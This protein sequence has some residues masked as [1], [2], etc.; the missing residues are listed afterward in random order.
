ML[1]ITV[2]HVSVA[3][4]LTGPGPLVC[5]AAVAEASS[6]PAVLDMRWPSGASVA[7]GGDERSQAGPSSG[8][9]DGRA[10][11]SPGKAT[12]PYFLI[13]VFFIAFLLFPIIIC[14]TPHGSMLRVGI[15]SGTCAVIFIINLMGIGLSF[16]EAA[17]VSTQIF[18]TI[19]YGDW[20]TEHLNAWDKVGVAL[21]IVVFLTVPA[22]LLH[23]VHE[24]SL[25]RARTNLENATTQDN[26]ASLK[27]M[28]RVSTVGM[29]LG[30][31]FFGTLFFAFW[32]PCSC[33]DDEIKIRDCNEKDKAACVS[34][35]G[36]VKTFA[37]SLY[38]SVIT[39]TTIGFGDMTPLTTLGHVIAVPWM[40]IGVAVTAQ[41]LT[42]I[43]DIVDEFSYEDP[44][45]KGMQ[46]MTRELFHQ[47]DEDHSGQLSKNEFRIGLLLRHSIVSR[48]VLD[49]IDNNFDAIDGAKAG[50]L[51]FEEIKD[52]DVAKRASTSA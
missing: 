6:W 46:L 26:V 28:H 45:F 33:G 4:L 21:F 14:C 16:S 22:T 8:S 9:A 18:S 17:Y 12:V 49:A 34:T 40:I 10:G 35:G 11:T 15:L 32:E 47:V 20:K 42:Q 38:M 31:V 48:D 24:Y 25:S 2:V 13:S 7:N 27:H 23:H 19:G 52:W 1:L 3:S 37:N 50:R 5:D 44:K 43:M 36:Q 30:C 39:L 51:T 41:L 29:W